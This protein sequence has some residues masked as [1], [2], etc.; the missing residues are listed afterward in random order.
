MPDTRS[1]CCGGEI[2]Y[3]MDDQRNIHTLFCRECGKDLPLDTPAE[4]KL[5]RG[6]HKKLYAEYMAEAAALEKAQEELTAKHV[7]LMEE[8]AAKCVADYGSHEDDGSM[9]HGFCTRCGI[10]LG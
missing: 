7:K 4:E 3:L 1:E 5:E 6:A 9:F 2:G 10:C 8:M